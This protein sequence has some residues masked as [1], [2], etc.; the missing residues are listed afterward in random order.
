ML[1]YWTGKEFKKGK[2]Q[3]I[4]ASWLWRP[5]NS[6]KAVRD[7]YRIEEHMGQYFIVIGIMT[8]LFVF[9]ILPLL[10]I[11]ALH[12]IQDSTCPRV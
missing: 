6:E 3:P 10:T 9:L 11:S 4:C 7:K 1:C 2:R 5:L 8:V 12:L